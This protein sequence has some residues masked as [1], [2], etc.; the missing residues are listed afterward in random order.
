MP[1]VWYHQDY[2]S[3]MLNEESSHPGL[4]KVSELCQPTSSSLLANCKHIYAVKVRIACRRAGPEFANLPETVRLKQISVHIKLFYPSGDMNV[5]QKM[6]P[7]NHEGI[8]FGSFEDS[9]FSGAQK[10][11]AMVNGKE[12]PLNPD[13]PTGTIVV[14]DPMCE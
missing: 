8:W 1:P 2:R 10:V 11:V 14:D 12:Y 5:M 4:H 13:D 3:A 7:T 9:R 6:G